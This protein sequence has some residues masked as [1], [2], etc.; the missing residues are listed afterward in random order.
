MIVVDE[1]KYVAVRNHKRQVIPMEY[2][3]PEISCEEVRE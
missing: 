1:T 3:R 2:P